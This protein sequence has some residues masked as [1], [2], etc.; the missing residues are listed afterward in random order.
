MA[1]AIMVVAVAMVVAGLIAMITGSGMI[2]LERGWS[3]VIA[4][5]IGATGGAILFAL[6]LLLREL[7]RLPQRLETFVP[8]EDVPA[9]PGIALAPVAPRPLEPK[10][11]LPISA[12]TIQSVAPVQN[13][14]PAS[15]R[16]PIIAPA[17][18][19]E[20]V[21]VRAPEP[22]PAPP[23][24]DGQGPDDARPKAPPVVVPPRNEASE[25]AVVPVIGPGEMMHSVFPDFSPRDRIGPRAAEPVD[26]PIEDAKPTMTETL[27]ANDAAEVE[28]PG[29]D[30]EQT[31]KA[32]L[33]PDV[34]APATEPPDEAQATPAANED[35]EAEPSVVGTYSSGGNV[36][37]MYADGSIEADTPDG[38]FRFGS[39]DELKAYIAS[40]ANG[41]EAGKRRTSPAI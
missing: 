17:E 32:E 26:S 18:R 22:A 9:D 11:E 12:E 29:V 3:A 41:P 4:G 15:K 38:V 39:L 1:F 31:D 8:G 6:A 2:A 24:I 5:T 40:G 36:Y 27:A 25:E 21:P 30:E 20:P 34:P 14:T 23:E 16:R 37:V 28:E 10:A 13:E 33:A 7:N 19:I 35:K